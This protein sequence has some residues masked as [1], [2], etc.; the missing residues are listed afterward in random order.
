MS[1]WRDQIRPIVAAIISEA[2]RL[3]LNPK[4]TRQALR[5]SKPGW[6]SMQHW[7]YRVWRSEC[8]IQLGQAPPLA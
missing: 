8:R 2:K 5:N 4:Q 1:T 3:G 7:P 6:V